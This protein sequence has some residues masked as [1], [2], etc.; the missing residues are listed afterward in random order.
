MMSGSNRRER[1][2]Q[3]TADH[4]ADTAW[5]LFQAQGFDAV[6]MEA[7]AENADVAKGTLY[8]YFPVKEALLRHQF[9]R[10]LAETMPGILKQLSDLPTTAERLQGFLDLSSDWSIAH[11]QHIGPYLSL[12]MNEAGIPY[13]LKAQKRSGVEQV[14]SGFIK[15]GQ[16]SGEFRSDLEATTA[17]QYLEFLY[18]ASLMRWLNSTE[19]DL[20]EEFRTM[21]DLFLYGLKS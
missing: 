6:T 3:Q 4:L 17:A 21:L 16:E 19:I 18:L 11:R 20:H 2:R 7:I 1:K 12:R 5:S 8:K 13:N 9:H 15:E 10:E 14:F